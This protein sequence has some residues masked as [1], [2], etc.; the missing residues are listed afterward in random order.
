MEN[1]IENNSRLQCRYS[2]LY[3]YYKFPIYFDNSSQYLLNS[4]MLLI[5]HMQQDLF[6]NALILPALVIYT[7]FIF[8]SVGIS[9]SN[10]YLLRILLSK[11]HKTK[12]HSEDRT[13][14]VVMVRQASS[15]IILI[16]WMSP[17]KSTRL[18]CSLFTICSLNS[19][20]D[21]PH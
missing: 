5:T 18:G 3:A 9:E 16:K 1:N 20:N 19:N 11:F 10:C 12:S 2:R 7:E 13:H 21:Q 17:L 8:L 14:S 4:L 15:L 6:K